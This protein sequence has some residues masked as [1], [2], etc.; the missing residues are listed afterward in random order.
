MVGRGEI[1]DAAWERIAPLLPE[2]GRPGGRWRDH[3]V[4]VDGVLWKLR[5]GAPWR[6]LLPGRYGP[7][8]AC[9]DRRFVRWRRGGTREKPPADVQTRGDAAGEVEEWVVSVDPAVARGSARAR[10][11]GA[12]GAEPGGQKKG[13]EHPEDGALGRGRGGLSTE[14]HSCCDGGGRPSS[15]VATPGQRDDGTR[16]SAVLGAIRVARTGRGRP[17]KRPERPIADKKSYGKG[18]TGACS[19][20]AASPAPSPSGGTT[21]GGAPGGPDVP[22]AWTRGDLRRTRRGREVREPAQAV[23]ARDRAT[24]Y[25]KRA[26]N[27]YRAMVMNASLMMWP[28]S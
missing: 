6:D 2:D 10:R 13:V 5:T 22:R 7:W 11:G 4:V 12:Q 25:E 26:A 15:V 18:A 23:V 14:A 16:L 20:L 8:R 28:P 9:Y 21:V 27:N 24:R 3:R 1:T 19:G 17:R